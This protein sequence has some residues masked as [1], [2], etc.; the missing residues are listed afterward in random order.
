MSARA[1]L[2]KEALLA[3]GAER[4]A[5][6]VLDEAGH[7]GSF[8][9]MVAA[10]LAGAKGPAA[11]AAFVDRRLAALERARGIIDWEKRRA[12]ATDLKATLATMVSELGGA[13]PAAAV[14][15]IVRFLASAERIFDRVD[16]SSGSIQTIF[17]DAAAAV[18]ALAKQ[19]PDESKTVL[20]E[21][22]VKLLSNDGY[23]LIETVFHDTVP[24]LPAS[25]LVLVDAALA[26][27]LQEIGSVLE[28]SQDWAR[29]GRRD[30]VIRARQAIAD[31]AGDVDAFIGLELERPA[32]LSDSLGVAERLLAAGRASEALD[33]VRRPNRPGIRAM[34][35]EDLAD[36]T[37]G[38]D[39]PDRERVRLEIRILAALGE[40]DAAQALRWKTFE[41]GLYEDLLRDYLAR[42][43]DLEDFDALDRAFAYAGTHPRRYRA[44]A[45]LLAWPRLDLAAKLVIDNHGTWDGRHYG[46]LVPAAEELEHDHPAAAVVLYRALIDDILERARSAAYGH[47]ARY[48]AKLDGLSPGEA[49][50][51]LGLIDHAGHRAALKLVHG[52]KSGFWALVDEVG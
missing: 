51:S 43:P 39:L 18:P 17:H 29:R 15:R 35:E 36:A 7:N 49:G 44:L 13:D 46:A 10:A 12:F 31:C 41:E 2:T 42:L 4:L 40:H 47:A 11:V 32:R 48:L 37:P 28:D 1:T 6:L 50:I 9:K 30:R 34:N 20:F 23:G 16:D 25:E 33:W 5:R 19:M 22:L 45:F 26:A 14:D 52:R 27:S 21:R 24:L 3:L 8:K 38:V